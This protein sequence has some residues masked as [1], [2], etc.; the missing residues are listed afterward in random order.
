MHKIFFKDSIDTVMIS[1]YRVIVVN[2]GDEMPLRNIGIKVDDELYRKIK[3]KL[4]K[5]DKRLKDYI[6]ELITKDLDSEEKE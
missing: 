5:E 3:I 4:A 6:V 1:C 2:G